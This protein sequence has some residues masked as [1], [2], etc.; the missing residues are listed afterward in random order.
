MAEKKNN[1]FIKAEFQTASKIQKDYKTNPFEKYSGKFSAS[2]GT[3]LLG[4]CLAVIGLVLLGYSEGIDNDLN[5][6]RR[7][8][9]IHESNLIRNSGM[10]K[11]TGMPIVQH[12]LTI[13]GSEGEFL[14]YIKTL[15]EKVDGDW[16]E[17]NKEQVFSP[18]KVGE[19]EIDSSK[20]ELAFDL[21]DISEEEA[22][23][24]REIIRGVPIQNELVVV[25]NLKNKSISDGV[26]FIITNKSNKDLVGSMT[27]MGTM[28][29][30][31][32]KIGALLLITLGITSFILPILTFLD[33]FPHIGLA[34]MGLIMLFS[35]LVAALLVFIAAIVI[36]FWWLIFIIVGLVIILLIRIKSRK[37]YQP[38]S[39][40]P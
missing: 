39:F 29:W 10:I 22:G 2:F 24:T 27:H 37:K 9:L 30:W 35:F 28:E 14:Y 6:V 11:L 21:V 16:I 32:Y 20:A 18:F 19:I 5:V 31:L 12:P 4:I 3:L 36:T 38:I 25:G 7:S 15:E 13:P 17:V 23:D 34:A 8:P 26:V 33:V 40:V 1:K